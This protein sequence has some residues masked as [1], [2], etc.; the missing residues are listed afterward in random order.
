LARANCP[1]AEGDHHSSIVDQGAG[2]LAKRG[3]CP[4]KP[5]TR[6]DQGE[7]REAMGRFGRTGLVVVESSSRSSP[8]LEA[9]ASNRRRIEGSTVGSTR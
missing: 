7:G 3:W 2:Q 1:G 5:A 8:I 9:R 6:A 4:S